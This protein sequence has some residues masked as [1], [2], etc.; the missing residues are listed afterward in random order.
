MVITLR[1]ILVFCQY[2]FRRLA[3]IEPRPCTRDS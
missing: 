2:L 3:R 1:R